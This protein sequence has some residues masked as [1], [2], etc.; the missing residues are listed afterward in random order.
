MKKAAAMA[1]FNVLSQ[2]LP[3]DTKANHKIHNQDNWSLGQH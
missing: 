2:N 1:N 3:Q